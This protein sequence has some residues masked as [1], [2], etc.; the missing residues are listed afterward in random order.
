MGV[1]Q[2]F[3]MLEIT[4]QGIFNGL[5]RTTPPPAIISMV[6]NTLRIPLAL[7]LVRASG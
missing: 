1:S 7:F 3:M 4:T 5:G 2:I 6:F